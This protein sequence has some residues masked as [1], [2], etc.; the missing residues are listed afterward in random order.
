MSGQRKASIIHTPRTY[1]RVFVSGA[2][3]N[4]EVRMAAAHVKDASADYC[5]SHGIEPERLT[6]NLHSVLPVTGGHK[7]TYVMGAGYDYE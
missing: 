2:N 5:I 6:V 7:L 3:I 4:D 1:F